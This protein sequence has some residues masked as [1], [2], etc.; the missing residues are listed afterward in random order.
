MVG[1]THYR[2][3]DY[4]FFVL[5]T[6]PVVC[7]CFLDLMWSS[8]AKQ[9]TIEFIAKLRDCACVNQ[10]GWRLSGHWAYKRPKRTKKTQERQV[11]VSSRRDT[12][13]TTST[14]SEG[15]QR[16]G[17]KKERSVFAN[18]ASGRGRPAC[19]PSVSCMIH[20]NGV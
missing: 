4:L 1:C 10:V 20:P 5:A 3:C 6:T 19:Q 9:L 2:L 15:G 13:H 11:S 14:T 18:T 17:S 7:C 12:P 8:L 16:R